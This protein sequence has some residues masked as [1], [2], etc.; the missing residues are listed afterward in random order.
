MTCPLTDEGERDALKYEPLV[1]A[2][3]WVKGNQYDVTKDTQQLAEDR[4]DV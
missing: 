4:G 3:L 2:K 1:I